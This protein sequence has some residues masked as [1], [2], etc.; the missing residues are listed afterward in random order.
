M[1]SRGARLLLAAM[2][3]GCAPERAAAPPRARFRER[4]AG[5]GVDFVHDPGGAGQK[6]FPEIMG[7]GVSLFDSDGDGDLDLW[8]AHGAAMPGRAGSERLLDRLY[9]NDGGFRFVDVTAAS[10]AGE[11]GYTFSAACPDVDGDGDLDLYV[12]NLGRDRLLVNDGS[13]R[14]TEAPGGSG[15]D[16]GAWSTCAAFADLDRDGD[17]DA[18]VG[19]YVAFDLAD[20]RE[21]GEVARGPQFRAYPHPDNFPGARDALLRNDGG[22]DGAVRFTDVTVEAGLGRS[23]GKALAVVPGD[24]DDDGDV[25]LFVGN[26][27][28]GNFLWRND[29]PPGGPI[30]LANVAF[31]VCVAQDGEGR[32]ESSMGSST[33]TATSTSSPRACRTK[34][35]RSG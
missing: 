6:L 13:G 19:N 9:R 10:G 32:N 16:G 5:S 14:F 4:L 35:T 11:E 34:P 8:F 2:A 33:T 7:G 20:R 17:L 26:D 22:R 31:E 23:D 24:F 3:A 1:T 25:D 12:C 21:W 18:Y 15:L 28:T 27:R 30:R 29:S